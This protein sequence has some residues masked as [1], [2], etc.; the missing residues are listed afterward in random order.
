MPYNRGGEV[1]SL[2]SV[3]SWLFAGVNAGDDHDSSLKVYSSVMMYNGIGWSEIFRGWDKNKTIGNLHWQTIPEGRSRLWISCDGELISIVFPKGTLN[4]SQDRAN[5]AGNLLNYTFNPQMVLDTSTYD[6]GAINQNK[7]YHKL[8]VI[9]D[10]LT[11]EGYADSG[12][13]IYVLYQTDARVGP[14]HPWIY[15]GEIK[16]SPSDSVDLA[17]GNIKRLRI[18]LILQHKN[19]SG[20]PLIR[21]TVL[22]GFVRTPHKRVWV[23]R[24]KTSPFQVT[25][26]GTPDTKPSVLY[27]WLNEKIDQADKLTMEAIYDS[28]HN[29]SVIMDQYRLVPKS[30]D[31]IEGEDSYELWMT[32]REA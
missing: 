17:I 1:V 6:M 22:E 32:L 11:R 31:E 10:G 15:A 8:S 9:S 7:Y 12:G 26:M 30:H 24:T 25:R 23:V 4:P 19:I 18:R 14:T 3:Y 28:M 2:L 21:A 16:Y 27:D 13:R 5:T 20:T 29:H